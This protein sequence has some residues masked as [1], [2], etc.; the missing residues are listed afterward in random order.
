MKR[1]YTVIVE[2]DEDG[3]YIAEVPSLRSCYTQGDSIE[4]VMERIKE[5]MGLC[6]KEE[7][8]ENLEFVSLQRLEMAA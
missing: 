8:P 7:E 6:E 2:K 4:Q 5:V 1:A 3:V